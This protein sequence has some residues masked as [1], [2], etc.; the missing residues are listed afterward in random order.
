MGPYDKLSVPLFDVPLNDLV[1]DGL[2]NLVLS[3][4]KRL[5][6]PRTNRRFPTVSLIPGSNVAINAIADLGLSQT[7]PVSVTTWHESTM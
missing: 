1:P 2:I 6:D 7:V 5:R 4:S 3:D